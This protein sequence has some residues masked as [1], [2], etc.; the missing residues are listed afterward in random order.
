MGREAT[1]PGSDGKTAAEIMSRKKDERFR[2]LAKRLA[3][4][5]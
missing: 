3:G 1:S 5:G 2:T 4:A